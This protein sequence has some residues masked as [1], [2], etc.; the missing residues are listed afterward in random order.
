MSERNGLL[1]PAIRRFTLSHPSFVC[2]GLMV[3][4]LTVD[5]ATGRDIRFPLLYVLPIGMAAWM[6]RRGTAYAYAVFMPAARV[7]FEVVWQVP[8]RLRIEGINAAI[9]A[10]AMCL[11][12]FLVARQGRQ[13]RQL[14]QTITEREGEMDYLRAFTRLIGTTLQGRGVSSGLA[15]GVAW[16]YKTEEIVASRPRPGAALDAAVE[17]NRFDSAVASSVRE[18]ETMVKILKEKG[19]EDEISLIEVHLALLNDPSLGRKCRQ[20]IREHHMGAEEALTTVLAEMEDRLARLTSSVLRE[21]AADVR[22]V[23]RRLLRNLSPRDSVGASRLAALPRGTVLVA[24]ELLLSDV[25]QLDRANVVGFVTARTGAGSH[26]AVWARSH[27]IP[28]VCGIENATSL[29][30]TGERVLVDADVGTVTIAPTGTQEARFAV[31][32]AEA[33][34]LATADVPEH[35]QECKTKDGTEIGLY[36][37]IGHPDEVRMVME[38]RLDGVGLFR[39]EFLFLDAGR[40]P[41]LE[42]QLAA[43]CGVATALNPRPV[44]IRTMDLGGDKMPRFSLPSTDVA[45]RGGLRGLAFSL[46]ERSLF[47]SQL[48][49]IL[50]A[51]RTGNVRIL[52]PMVMG[53]SDMNEARDI[54]EKLAQGDLSGKCPLLGAMVETPASVLAIGE[55][56]GTADFISIGTNDLSHSIL[57][58]DRRIQGDSAA[59]LLLHPAVLRAVDQVV[60]AADQR[61]VPLFVC[62][63]ATG[64][65]AVACLLVGL[66]VR[67]LSLSPFQVPR[68]RGVLRGLRV[69]DAQ[70]AARECLSA[71][72]H[73]EAREVLACL[74]RETVS[75]SEGGAHV[76]AAPPQSIQCADD[77]S[78]RGVT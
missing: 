62:G 6:G 68:V 26:A 59:S 42:S 73:R 15:D 66:G 30:A 65:C 67:N 58:M 60:R 56:V 43:Y 46:S 32:M 39:S 41:D 70:R 28:A 11:Y 52:F 74:L 23:G 33:T 61:R 18:V 76:E 44:V 7:L 2:F 54:I 69:G 9:E 25:L 49:A 63:E 27:R 31:R 36:A 13:S 51:A 45:L 38:H 77:P 12:V 8:E 14:K 55:I 53:P 57:A 10:L 48:Q 47:L 64:E 72:T 17:E 24:E 3:A 78:P 19:A 37:T 34:S 71:S 5:F 75:G 29:L 20:M 1:A 16:V 21:R 50:R 40:P 22:D 4:T 35:E